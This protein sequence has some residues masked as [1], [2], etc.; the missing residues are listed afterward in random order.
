MLLR[1]R[2]D[3]QVNHLHQG[4]MIVDPVAA[5]DSVV[6]LLRAVPVLLERVA[7]GTFSRM[8]P[9]ISHKWERE[10]ESGDIKA[11]NEG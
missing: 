5:A 11:R 2:S 9:V 3:L 8:S 10:M 6:H 1:D 7:G 4:A